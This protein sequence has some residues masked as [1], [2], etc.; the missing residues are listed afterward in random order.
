MK[1]FYKTGV[2]QFSFRKLPE[3][4]ILYPDQ[5]KIKVKYTTICSDENKDIGP[6]DYFSQDQ[7]AGH[8]MSGIIVELGENA[9]RH[10]F[11]VG[12]PVG[13]TATLSCGKCRMCLSG[14]EHCCLEIK[15]T[16]GSLCEFVV[17]S[18]RQLVRLP[19]TVPLKASCLIEPLTSILQGM[20]HLDVQIGDYVAIWGGGFSGLIFAKLEKMRGASHVTVVEPLEN[21]RKLALTYGADHVIDPTL[22]GANIHLANITQF[23]GFGKVVET[24]SQF[25]V[26]HMAL[27]NL[28]RGATLLSFTYYSF[29]KKHHQH[30]PNISR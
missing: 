19:D 8:E 20:E 17:R 5:V 4:Q 6:E 14:R 11:R 25:D 30:E 9:Y 2:G 27:Q 3:P 23:T 13:G 1:A 28:S 10:G 12:D 26:Y 24:S 22:P 7:I 18:Y 16:T 29:Y 15:H 21:R